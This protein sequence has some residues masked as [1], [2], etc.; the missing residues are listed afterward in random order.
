MSS[1]TNNNS[2]TAN[3]TTLDSGVAT[4]LKSAV[5]LMVAKMVE[6]Q[7][8]QLGT[9]TTS[10][11]VASLVELVYNQI[12]NLGEDLE[13]FANHADRTVIKPNDMYMVSRKNPQLTKILKDIEQSLKHNN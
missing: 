2:L 12:I 11:Y 10:T 5:Y 9:S 1:S 4:Q 3:N 13:L 6:E 8:N 7:A